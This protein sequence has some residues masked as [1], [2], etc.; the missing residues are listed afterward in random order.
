[1]SILHERY[2]PGADTGEEM[3]S[4]AGEEGGVVVR[5]A[6]ELTVGGQKRTLG[7]GDAYYFESRLPHRFRNTGEEICEII[8]ANS[9]PT[10]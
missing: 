2:N 6:I 9:P 3:L 10:F 8:S 4:H 5:G 1:M 7:P